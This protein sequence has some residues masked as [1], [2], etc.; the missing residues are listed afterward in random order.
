MDKISKFL[1]FFAYSDC[2]PVV[3]I[4]LLQ[5][6]DLNDFLNNFFGYCLGWWTKGNLK[7]VAISPST[8]ICLWNLFC[9]NYSCVFI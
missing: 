1:K 5:F 8:A 3:S 4:Y 9:R 2:R 7:A 6:Y